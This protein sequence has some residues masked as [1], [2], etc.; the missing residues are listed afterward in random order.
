M[1]LLEEAVELRDAGVRAPIL[2][3]G[4]YYGGA[5]E[6]VVARGVMQFGVYERSQ[7]EG[8]ARAAKQAGRQ[9]E[10]HLTIDTGMARL[11]VRLRQSRVL[12]GR[13]REAPGGPHLRPHDPSRVRGRAR[14][15]ARA[16]PP[17]RGG[18]EPACEARHRTAA[19]P[20]R[21]QRGGPGGDALFDAV[22]PGVAIFG[23]SPLSREL[24]E[25]RAAMRVRSEIV[26]L[27]TIEAGEPVGYGALFRAARQTRIA[28]LPM[29][30]ADGLSR[31]LSNRGAVLVRGKRCPIVGAVSMDI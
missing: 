16:G 12:R 20:R 1:A 13:G 28:T 18:D 24:P 30:Y 31:H 2:V 26:D 9:I 23:V 22:R 19:S 5:Y 25:L 21:E 15:D 17:V 14:G 29:G 8:L 11:G 27:R 4:G 6:E 7:L 3:M 10:A